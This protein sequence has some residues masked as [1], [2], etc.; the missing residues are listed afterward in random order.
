MSA[1]NITKRQ[2]EGVVI[3]DLSGKIALGE[4]N[5]SFHESLRELVKEGKRNI[6]LNMQNVTVIDSSGLGEL[7]AGYAT[8][9]NNGGKL[10]LANLSPRITEVMTITKLVTVFDVF[11]AESDALASFK[12]TTEPPE[13]KA[14][15]GNSLL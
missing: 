10:K 12:E 5:R 14:A 13:E 4:T 8:V 15:T 6:L 3:L 1:L 11:D 7:V 9:E 2:L